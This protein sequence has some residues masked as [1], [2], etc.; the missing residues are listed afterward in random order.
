MRVM[1]VAANQ[2]HRPDPVVPLGA[3]YVAGAARA[4]GHDVA[5]ADL[6]FEGE[7]FAPGLAAKI[8]AHRPDVVGISLRNVDDVAWPRARSY[9]AHYRRVVATV[10][11]AAPRAKV[12]LGGPA[13]TLFPEPYLD[14]LAPDHG[15]AGEGERAFVD[16]LAGRVSD[17]LI[18]AEVGDVGGEPALDLV[19]ADRYLRTGGAVSVQT[20]RG[21]PFRCGYCTYPEL[22]GATPRLR[23]AREVVDG[24]ERSVASG[25]D[26]FF[27]VDNVFNVPPRHAAG[28]C[29]EI[30][31]R[32]LKVRWTAF[33]TPASLDGALVEK[34]VAAGCTSVDMG[35]DAAHP[36]TLAALGKPFGPDQIRE[37]GRLCRAAGLRFG[38]S[39]ILGGPSETW[40]TLAATEALIE[41]TDPT[42]VVGMLGVR[43]YRDTPLGRLAVREGWVEAGDIGLEPLFYIA[44]AVRDGLADWAT[45]VAKA[46]SRWFFPGL[47]G[48]RMD[49]YFAAVRKRGVRG[50]LWELLG[51]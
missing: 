34:M 24:I 20:R 16:L 4:A 18:R 17:R 11:E 31:A 22:E 12:V 8:A 7:G 19:D 30:L 49:R 51:Q 43:L 27:F 35:T 9:L 41:E 26:S 1:M 10:R 32:G 29:D 47:V 28:I 44:P 2:E 23:S 21:C 40:E 14:A 5:L 42:A 13:F 3:I 36:A 39:L 37:A 45:G 25:V 46:R 48:D 50:P 15:V 33:V 38:H 6:C